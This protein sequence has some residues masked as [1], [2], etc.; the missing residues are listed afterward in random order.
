MLKKNYFHKI[1]RK[2]F[3]FQQKFLD[4]YFPYISNFDF[5]ILT[6]CASICKHWSIV[7]F[8]IVVCDISSTLSAREI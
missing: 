8:D 5:I 7:S 3:D 1:M 2:K 6:C 4:H